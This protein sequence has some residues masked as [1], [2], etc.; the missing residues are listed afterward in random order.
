MAVVP[1]DCL[2]V[3]FVSIVCCAIIT[4]PSS[5]QAQS[6][7]P[8]SDGNSIDQGIA[9]MLMVVAL[10]LTYLIHAADFCFSF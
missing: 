4:L 1:M 10:L 2:V 8:T 7:S 3:V 9:C 5:I 6:S